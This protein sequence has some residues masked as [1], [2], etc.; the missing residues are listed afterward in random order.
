[1]SIDVEKIRNV[2][3]IAHGGAGKTSLVEAMLFDSKATDRMGNIGDGNTVTDFEAEE[4]ERKISISSALA[5][6]DWNGYRLNIIDTPGYINFIEDTK[7]S[8]S[9][10]DGA[11]VIVSALS[12]VKAETGKI[13]Q[14]ADKYEVPRIVFVNKMDRENASFQNAVEGVENAYGTAAIPLNIPMGAASTLEGIIDI[15]KMK[16]VKFQ[17]GRMSEMDI[18]DAFKADAEEYRK[19]LIEKVAESDDELLEKYLEGT[20][21]T[22]EEINKGIRAGAVSGAFVPVVCGSAINNIGVQQLLDTVLF[23]LPSPAEKANKNAIKG[24]NP[25]TGEEVTRNPVADDPLSLRVFKTIADPFAGKLTLFRVFSGVLKS[26]SNIYNAGRDTKEKM[27][28]MFYL[29]GKKQVPVKKAG[30]GEMAAVAK[31]KDAQTGDT[32]TDAGNPVLFDPVQFSDPMISYAIDPK[33]RGDEEK[34]STGIQRLLEEDPTLKFHRDTE[35]KEMIIGGMGQMHLE[36]TLQKLKRKFG[37]EVI[38]KS[39]KIPYRETIKASSSAQGK[40]KKQSGGRGQFGDCWI[41]IEPLPRG[42]GFEFVNQI[43]GGVIP[44]QYIPAVEKGIVEKMKEGLIA[45][46][47]VIDMK[48]ALYDGSYHNVDSSEM[49]FKIAGSMALQKAAQNAKAVLL[50]PIVKVEVTTPEE[51]LG[52]VIG[53]LNS[54]RGKVQGVEALSGRDQKIAALVPMAEMLTYANQ[55]NSLT[56]GQGMYTMEASHYEEVPS[57]IAQK[58]IAQKQEAKEKE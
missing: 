33:S 19:K 49:A 50:E 32:L 10:V 18:P 51:F 25:K 45:G 47:Q 22:D 7:C 53:D 17:G 26:D 57:H 21:P 42:T 43:V 6:C 44:R 30:P 46:Y 58:I 4:I 55:L 37:V 56:S 35:T 31:L 9:A 27:G 40:Y 34:V 1:M 5:F 41:K 24:K 16:A 11:I 20:D 48:A 15:I 2:A 36:V 38:M 3:V 14:F 39:P 12:G 29:L 28:N 52:N 54:K 13:W 8:L 23:C